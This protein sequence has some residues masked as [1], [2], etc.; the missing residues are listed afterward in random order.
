M[1][2]FICGTLVFGFAITTFER[3]LYPDQQPPEDDPSYLDYQDYTYL[4]NGMWLV[5]LVMTTV[6][7]GEL[8]PKTHS[9]RAVC[10]ITAFFG[11]F[12]VSLM[13][14]TLTSS[15][16]FSKYQKQAYDILHRL[17][18]KDKMKRFGT[19]AIVQWFRV[20]KARVKLKIAIQRKDPEG[21]TYFKKERGEEE[22]ILEHRFQ[23]FKNEKQKLNKKEVPTEELLNQL[24]ERMELDFDAIKDQLSNIES[25]I[26]Y[27]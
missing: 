1:L 24:T 5:V 9:G 12:L 10:V 6:G 2:I 4:W 7:Y 18:I 15:S 22:R 3:P 11:V 13:V 23:L 20:A 8:F 27:I 26:T 17:K 16:E 25:K 19:S 14:V 21:V